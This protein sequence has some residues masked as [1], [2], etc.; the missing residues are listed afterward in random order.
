MPSDRFNQF[1]QDAPR[2]SSPLDRYHWVMPERPTPPQG[3]RWSMLAPVP[4]TGGGGGTATRR[5]P[6][7]T[8]AGE[9]FV[10]RWQ[11]SEKRARRLA[12]AWGEPGVPQPWSGSPEDFQSATEGGRG[13]ELSKVLSK[14]P[15]P[16]PH[17]PEHNGHAPVGATPKPSPSGLSGGAAKI[18]VGV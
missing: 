12:K 11:A 3:S 4:R 9:Q 6:L 1:S 13:G 5:G 17:R 10:Q 7:D 18:P 14:T 16:S 15:Y 2:F 8:T